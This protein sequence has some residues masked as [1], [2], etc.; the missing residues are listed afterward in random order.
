MIIFTLP[1]YLR[2]HDTELHCARKGLLY[3]SW[4]GTW[5]CLK[6]FLCS[7]IGGSLRPNHYNW[8]LG[9]TGLHSPCNNNN[10]TVCKKINR[11]KNISNKKH[12]LSYVAFR[13]FACFLFIYSINREPYRS[14]PRDKTAL[15]KSKSIAGPGSS[16]NCK[17]LDLFHPKIIVIFPHF[18]LL[19]LY[20]VR[21]IWIYR[22]K[23]VCSSSILVN[24][25]SCNCK[26]QGIKHRACISIISFALKSNVKKEEYFFSH[27]VL[28][29]FRWFRK[30]CH[31]FVRQ[32]EYGG[33]SVSSPPEDVG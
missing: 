14:I 29:K 1:H 7:S 3:R 8:P 12:A 17:R 2:L 26:I 25:I 19:Y 22:R 18:R 9:R 11:N 31:I 27:A 16:W 5:H 4:V 28:I 10:N 20:W 32:T 24:V 15:Y 21:T 30:I 6:R 13:V 33:L 23:V